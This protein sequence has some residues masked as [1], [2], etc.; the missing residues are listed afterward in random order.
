MCSA[1]WASHQRTSLHSLLQS[2]LSQSRDWAALLPVPDKAAGVCVPDLPDSPAL[3]PC[4]L[5]CHERK[6]TAV[7]Q[8][9]ERKHAA[10]CLKDLVAT[11]S[12]REGLLLALEEAAA[13]EPKLKQQL[14]VRLT[15]NAKT[16][17]GNSQ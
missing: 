1:G 10:S 15:G 6:M 9:L 4:V 16:A 7:L 2:V 12:G 11:P 8:V 3:Q 13:S 5:H 17:S 14:L